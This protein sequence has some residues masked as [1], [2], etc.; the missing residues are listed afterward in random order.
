MSVSVRE[1]VV[2]VCLC[3]CNKGIYV[4]INDQRVWE[5]VVFVCVR[6]LMGS[7]P[8]HSAKVQ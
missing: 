1:C 3:V 8:E 7:S 5:I 2:Y 6:I 4:T